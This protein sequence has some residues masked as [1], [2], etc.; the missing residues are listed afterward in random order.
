ML[1]WEAQVVCPPLLRSQGKAKQREGRGNMRSMRS[2]GFR[3][4]GKDG[5]GPRLLEDRPPSLAGIP[6]LESRPSALS[7]Q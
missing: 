4:Q 7:P 6:F 3:K 1:E 2:Q 5:A